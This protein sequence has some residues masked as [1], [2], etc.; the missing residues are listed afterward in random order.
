M[1]VT[2][3]SESLKRL[4]SSFLASYARSAER[5]AEL[6]TGAGKTATPV[7][8]SD[9]FQQRYAAF[10]RSQG[11]RIVQRLAEASL[12]YYTVV[13]NAGVEA[14]K[15]YFEQVLQ[16]EPQASPAAPAGKTQSSLLFRGGFG[17]VPTNAFVIANNRNEAIDV[18]FGL[19]E[20][21]SD[22]GESRLR[23]AVR[24]DPERCRLGPNSQQVVH[25][26]MQLSEQ[27]RPGVDYRGQIQVAG[28]PDMSMSVTARVEP[29]AGTTGPATPG[30]TLEPP[31]ATAKPVVDTAPK[32][33]T[34][35]SRKSRS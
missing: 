32:K 33:A 21:M 1:D 25:C 4:G 2:E 8:S 34:T 17:E 29:S 9:Q 22:D 13:L 31:P 16:A 3:F 19:A 28:F 14:A 20:L 5:Y 10:V 15:L 6:V 26:S 18:G 12:N 35:R 30:K 24:F 11:P 7:P 23:P 27:F